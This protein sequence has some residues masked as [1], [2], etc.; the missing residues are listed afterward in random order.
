MTFVKDDKGDMRRTIAQQ[1]GRMNI[2]S[3]SGGRVVATENGIELPISNGY[4]VRIELTVM[5]DYTVSR[6]FKRAG[7]EWVKGSR[8]GV[9]CDEVGEIAYRAGMFRSYDEKEWVSS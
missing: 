1:V 6:I 3:I 9:Y 7:K 4:S 8:E 2:L 5:D